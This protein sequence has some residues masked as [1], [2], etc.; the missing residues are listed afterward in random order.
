M[1]EGWWRSKRKSSNRIGPPALAGRQSPPETAITTSPGV[2][3][4]GG[5][6]EGGVEEQKERQNRFGSDASAQWCRWWCDAPLVVKS[7]RKISNRIVL[8]HEPE[9]TNSSRSLLTITSVQGL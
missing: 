8:L 7:K 5:G 1:V 4:M 3:W 6:E 9:K 2:L